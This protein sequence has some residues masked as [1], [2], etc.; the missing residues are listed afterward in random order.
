[1]NDK[2]KVLT[3]MLAALLCLSWGCA[4]TAFK[5]PDMDFGAL[6]NIA[7]MP[8]E[9]LTSDEAAAERVRDAFMGGLL[10]TGSMYVIPAGEVK[11]GIERSGMRTPSSPTSEEIKKFGEIMQV[12]AVMTGVLREYGQVRSGS[13]A[14]NV[15][16]LSMQLLEVQT[17]KVVW[18]ASSTKGGISVSDR[19]FG[20][21]G[22]AMNAT[23]EDVVDE[24]L[25]KLFK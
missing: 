25:D 1:M 10:A 14:G 6:Q 17:G 19:L 12:E 16:S 7:V 3:A 21:G 11:R 8:F 20:G 9:N 4:S 15:I 2:R 22:Q 13:S 18:S 23:T 24:L 5:N